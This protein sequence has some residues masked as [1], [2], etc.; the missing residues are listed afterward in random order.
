MPRARAPAPGR[1]AQ[2][3]EGAA[4]GAAAPSPAAAPGGGGRLKA[5]GGASASTRSSTSPQQQQQ[6]QQQEQQQEQQHNRQRADRHSH[7]RRRSSSSLA[8]AAAALTVALAALATAPRPAGAVPPDYDPLAQNRTCTYTARGIKASA[9]FSGPKG[10]S[11]PTAGNVRDLIEADRNGPAAR[12]ATASSAES[13]SG[14]DSDEAPLFPLD[15]SA[16]A[17][18]NN[19]TAT[20]ATACFGPGETYDPALVAEGVK[21]NCRWR[22]SPRGGK[23]EE[24]DGGGDKAATATTSA[25]P[26]RSPW[27]DPDALVDFEEEQACLP[28][29]TS[30][31][32]CY[33][34]GRVVGSYCDPGLAGLG[35]GVS[36]PIDEC[37]PVVKGVVADGGKPVPSEEIRRVQQGLER[38]P[39]KGH[40]IALAVMPSK[41]DK[42]NVE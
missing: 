9:F 19:R 27:S 39:A 24:E 13:S 5:S 29:L 18:R 30:N 3:Q 34:V 36:F 37:A 14:D 16:R 21:H 42:F 33:S 40:Y 8:L 22:W 26:A 1:R 23:A 28:V 35:Q 17:F 38:P 4:A 25:P 11:G 6:Q 12:A 15:P 41:M 10:G 32:Y 31:C 7:R 20:A 2:Q